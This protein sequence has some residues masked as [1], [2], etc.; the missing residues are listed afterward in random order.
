[1]VYPAYLDAADF[2]VAPEVKPTAD[3]LKHDY[4][5]EDDKSYINSSLFIIMH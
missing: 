1:L 2:Q 4:S 5:T 3:T